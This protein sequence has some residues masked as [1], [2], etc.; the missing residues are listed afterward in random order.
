MTIKVKSKSK[1]KNS[2]FTGGFKGQSIMN[3]TTDVTKFWSN[4]IITQIKKNYSIVIFPKLRIQIDIHL[5][6]HLKV[7]QV[8]VTS[9]KFEI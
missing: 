9:Q 6:S 3:T 4:Q 2:C 7:K 8:G 5:I 1:F